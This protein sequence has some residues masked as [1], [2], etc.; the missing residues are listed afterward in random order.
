MILIIL[1]GLRFYRFPIYQQAILKSNCSR[2]IN[3]EGLWSKQDF[4]NIQVP[5]KVK[6]GKILLAVLAFTSWLSKIKFIFIIRLRS[7]WKYFAYFFEDQV[8][9][10]H[11]L[12]FDIWKLYFLHILFIMLYKLYFLSYID[13]LTVLPLFS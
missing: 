7:P 1:K 10:S 9:F 2:L 12:L 6:L 11:I 4:A 3:F 8:Y 13:F 5:L